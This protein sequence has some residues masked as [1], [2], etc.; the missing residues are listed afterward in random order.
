MDYSN[1]VVIHPNGFTRNSI[2]KLFSGEENFIRKGRYKCYDIKR[3]I[4]YY[5]R[6]QS[7]KTFKM[8]RNEIIIHT[9][10]VLA[11]TVFSLFIALFSEK[12]REDWVKAWQGRKRLVVWIPEKTLKNNEQELT[13]KQIAIELVRLTNC[14]KDISESLQD[15]EEVV[16]AGI[17]S[18]KTFQNSSPFQYASLRL[19]AKEDVVT[20]WLEKHNVLQY[21]SEEL[22]C[23]KNVVL[24]AVKS[25]P[26]AFDHIAS[27]ELREDPEI[28]ATCEKSKERQEKAYRDFKK[29]LEIFI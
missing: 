6:F 21:A 11:K 22:R 18:N 19:R 20:K 1:D 28:L 16:L 13:A 14:L 7:E 29:S 24:K 17:D 12:I 8:G 27:Q 2:F 26:Q 5:A 23:N 9:L 3:N 25:F 4:I 10:G 15:D